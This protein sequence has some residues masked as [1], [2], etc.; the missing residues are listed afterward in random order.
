ML[1]YVYGGPTHLMVQ[2]MGD[3][4]LTSG[5]RTKISSSPSWTTAA[6]RI[7]GREW[8]K[9]VNSPSEC[10]RGKLHRRPQGAGRIPRWTW[11]ASACS[12]GRLAAT[13][14]PWRCCEPPDVYKAAVAGGSGRR[15]GRRYDTHYTERY[16]G[17]PATHAAAYKEAS[18]LTYAAELNVRSVHI[19]RHGR[20]QRHTSATRSSSPTH[21][22][23]SLSLLLSASAV[24]RWQYLFVRARRCRHP[25]YAR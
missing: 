9:A 23:A 18:L 1:L 15:T 11:T 24:A 17:P 13:C 3:R 6:P 22:C 20:R 8:E 16:L 12:A 7:G 19:V 5:S 4:F 21:R 10:T 2:E 25:G 14:R